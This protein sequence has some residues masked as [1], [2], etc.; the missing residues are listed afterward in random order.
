M[1]RENHRATPAAGVEAVAHAP[2][3]EGLHESHVLHKD[4]VDGNTAIS[5]TYVGISGDLTHLG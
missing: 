1:Y 4:P 3:L 5:R 2:A